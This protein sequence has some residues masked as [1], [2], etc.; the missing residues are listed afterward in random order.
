MIDVAADITPTVV[1]K[2]LNALWPK[3]FLGQMFKIIAKSLRWWA[4]AQ[5]FLKFAALF[6][7]GAQERSS[8]PQ[9]TRKNSTSDRATK[10]MHRGRI[11]FGADRDAGGRASGDTSRPK[12]SVGGA[13]FWKPL[14][15]NR[16]LSQLSP[17]HLIPVMAEAVGQ[18]KSL[19]PFSSLYQ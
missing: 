10:C 1:Y 11:S 9:K 16:R 13:Y 7:P 12:R 8:K 18:L 14:Q 6:V 4:L 3:N 2:A 19:L 15:T 17:S 5:L